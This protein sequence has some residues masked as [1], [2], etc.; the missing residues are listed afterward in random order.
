MSLKHWTGWMVVGMGLLL[1]SSG[2]LLGQQGQS[3]APT[4]KSKAAKAKAAGQKDTT[5]AA[6]STANDNP[7]PEAQSAAAAK[8]EKTDNTPG[9]VKAQ[10][11]A[12]SGSNNTGT[13]PGLKLQ[14]IP[15]AS[16]SNQN[17][18][19]DDLGGVT[20]KRHGREDEFTRDLNP[21]GRLKDDLNV[22]NLY[23]DDWN[24][25]GAYLR[26]KDALQLDEYNEVAIFGLGK[27]ACMENRTGEAVAELKDYLNLYPDGKQ[28]KEAKKILSDP[29]K[30]VGNR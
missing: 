10:G 2:I 5:K 16:S 4:T 6:P 27:A 3:A 22:A 21:A 12:S 28:A 15:G 1:V 18:S 19:E 26:Y 24:Y 13:D 11:G 23:M 20:I 29:K 8:Q 9:A 17:M 25:A 30:C 14:P 7:F